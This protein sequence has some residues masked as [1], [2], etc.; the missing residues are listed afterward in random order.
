MNEITT[1]GLDLVKNVFHVEGQ[2]YPEIGMVLPDKFLEKR[3]FRPMM[4]EKD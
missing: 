4:L 2:P 3:L 1:V